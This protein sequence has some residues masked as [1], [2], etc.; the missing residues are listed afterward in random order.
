MKRRKLI[1]LLLLTTLLFASR[2][3]W[4]MGT[5][6]FDLVLRSSYDAV[7]ADAIRNARCLSP[8]DT[9][10][11][12]SIYRRN[13]SRAPVSGREI[14]VSVSFPARDASGESTLISVGYSA[15]T[16]ASGEA[17]VTQPLSTILSQ[18]QSQLRESEGWERRRGPIQVTF[19]TPDIFKKSVRFSP[20]SGLSF[21]LC[22]DVE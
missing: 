9:L 12:T 20:P 1:S 4:S 22:R 18:F 14:S 2:Y 10:S 21:R 7:T 11:V 6:P 19:S 16:N 3:S 8:S 13:R 5:P 17:V 15:T